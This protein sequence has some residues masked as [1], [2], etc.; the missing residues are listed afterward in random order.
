VAG[1]FIERRLQDNGQTV[2]FNINRDQ[3][4]IETKINGQKARVYGTQSQLDAY[5]NKKPDGTAQLPI[6]TPV[7]LPKGFADIATGLKKTGAANP[8]INGKGTIDESEPQKTHPSPKSNLKNLVPNPLEQFASFSPLWTLAVLTPEQ[9]NNPQLYRDDNSFGGG[10]FGMDD[11]TGEIWTDGQIIFSSGGRGDEYRTKTYHGQPEYFIDDFSMRTVVTAT[12]ETGTSN[13][14]KFDFTVIEPYSMGLLLQSMQNAAVKAGY[15]NYLEAPFVLK[16]DIQGWSERGQVISSIKPKFFVMKLTKATF[17]VNEGGSTYNVMGVPYNHN[18]LSDITNTLYKD[19]SLASGTKGTVEE[20]LVS[21]EESLCA[22]LNNNELDLVKQGK[23]SKPDVYEVQFPERPSEYIRSK[24]QEKDKGATQD[25]SK[26]KRERVITGTSLS[27]DVQQSGIIDSKYGNNPIGRSKFGFD[28][29]KGGNFTFKKENLVTN[30]ETGKV[31]REKMA[32]DPDKRTF[33]FKQSQSI[34]SIIEQIIT[35]ST[36][37]KDAVTAGKIAPDGMM[38]WFRIDVQMEYLEFD[39]LVGDYARKIIFRVVP[40]KV[41]HSI[42]SNPTSAPIGYGE[43]AKKI[44]KRYDYIYTGQN[45]DILKFD[46]QINNLFFTGI[47]PSKESDNAQISN[48]DQKGTVS[49]TAKTTSTGKGISPEAQAANLGRSRP[50]RDPE[51]LK[52]KVA[53]GSGSRDTEQ[54][55]AENFHQ[56]FLNASSADLIKVKLEILGDPYWLVD[57]GISNYFSP[58]NPISDQITEDGTMNFEGTDV[59]IFISFRTPADVNEKTG[60]YQFSKFEKESPFSGIYKVTFVENKFEDGNFI[61]EL[62]CIRMQGQPS[63]Y[64]DSIQPTDAKS[65]A[66]VV[67]GEAIPE[68]T[69]PVEEYDDDEED[70]GDASYLAAP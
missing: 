66:A 30:E 62:S 44:V 51:L 25:L 4:F 58:E 50:R 22:Y 27:G 8:I 43:L 6:A 1:E 56:A 21:G 23:I 41:H 37:A 26:Q 49:E 64:D 34:T 35:S 65:A 19:V 46:I 16:L 31:D 3:P 55:I 17:N 28:Q 9:F 36:Y 42:F 54:M 14:I 47:N 40:Y 24:K 7:S 32:V 59:Y 11:Q 10:D 61:Q 60:L 12:K 18:A 33:F 63:D 38:T 29:G 39:P 68:K 69:S 13:A 15:T 2:N 5:Q 52:N 53:G 57:S 45:A 20:L 48:P 70:Y 67:V